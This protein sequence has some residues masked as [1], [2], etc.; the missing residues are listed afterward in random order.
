[1]SLSPDGKTVAVGRR[2]QG[3]W[4]RELLRDAETRF[5][6]PP[7]AGGA[8][9]W[10]PDGRRIAFSSNGDLYRKD[11]AGGQEELLLPKDDSKNPSDWSR[12]GRFLIYTEIDPKTRGDLWVLPNAQGKSGEPVKFLQTEFI[13]SQAQF[14]PDGRWAG[15]VSP[16]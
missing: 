4:L 10:S 5:T 2:D 9:V 12:D 14:S 3:L 7:L 15:Y 1:M 8:P 13:E 6:F 11:A 16:N